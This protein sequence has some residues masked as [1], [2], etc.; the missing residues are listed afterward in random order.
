MAALQNIQHVSEFSPDGKLFAFI[1]S[2]G[3]LKIWDTEQNQQK[4]EY[5]PNLH[6]SAPC[7]CFTWIT[8]TSG[9]GVASNGH[10]SSSCAHNSSTKSYSL[11]FIALGQN[12]EVAQIVRS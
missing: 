11:L 3:K 4:Q 7:T 12:E 10:V 5:I 6:L 9:G 8:T 1:N 2:E